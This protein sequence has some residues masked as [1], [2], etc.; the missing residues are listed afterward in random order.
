MAELINETT[1]H[2]NEELIDRVFA[3][4]EVAMIK[5]IPLGQVA[6]EDVLTWPHSYDGRYTCKSR[7][8]FLKAVTELQSAQQ[9]THMD[10]K[11]W[12]GI[13]SLH[14]PNEV[15]NLT[16]RACRNAMPT[17]AN[18]VQRT[19]IDDPLCDRCHEAHETSLHAIWMCEEVDVIWA[20]PE[21][22][23]CW[24]EV[25][26]LNFK[27]LLSWMIEPQN[28][29][30]LFAMTAWVIRKQRNQVRLN[31]AA[32]NVDQ[33]A[34]QSNEMLAEFQACQTTST[35]SLS[36]RQTRSRQCW[37]APLM[38]MAKINFDGAIFFCENKSGI[39]V[40]IRDNLG[41][42]IAS[43]SKKLQQ[44]Y[45]SS[46]VKTL[47]AATALSFAADIGINKAILEGDSLEV[48]RALSQD[49]TTL[50]SIGPWIEDAKIYS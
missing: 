3:C 24:R 32:C 48:I 7:Y 39:G 18:A 28:N 20:D 21:L 22:W 36:E 5:K 29:S 47:A 40:V 23:S 15:K 41:F 44:A 34:Q 35:T 19:I 1:R 9:P 30:E 11:L 33:I 12:N 49:A 25:H 4:D 50:S 43:C 13:W 42:V 38:D 37:R 16:W 31:Q 45:S 10:S 17:K 6:V 26:F 2:W 46:E 27:E 8:R 14:V